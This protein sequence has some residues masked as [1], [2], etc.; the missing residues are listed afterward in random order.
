MTG[1]CHVRFC[2]RLGG[3][4]PPCLLGDFSSAGAAD[5]HYADF[6]PLSIAQVEGGSFGYKRG[7]FASS[8]RVGSGNILYAVELFH[9][10]G[11]W[12]NPDDYKKING[13][14]SYSRGTAEWGYSVTSM[15]Y[16]GDWNAT[17]QIA[18]RALE[19]IPDFGLFDSL[20]SSDG[21]DS[22]RHSLSAEWHRADADSSTKVFVIWILL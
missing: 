20:D 8:Q 10:D 1:D 12:T 6:L 22:Q 17:D 14:L 18:Q 2:E 19:E 3:E 4:I 21:G 11:P 5:I 9:N 16:V 15:S 7:L 13:V